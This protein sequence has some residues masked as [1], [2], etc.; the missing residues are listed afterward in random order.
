VWPMANPLLKNDCPRCGTNSVTFTVTAAVPSDGSTENVPPQL[1]RPAFEAFCVCGQCE[2]PTVFRL[3]AKP[4]NT[5][6]PMQFGGYLNRVFDLAGLVLNIP[7]AITSPSH[8]PQDIAIIF[9][10]AATCLAVECFDASGA[11]FRKVLDAATRPLLPS[12]PEPEDKKHPD[13][14]AWKIRKDLKLRLEWLFE[15]GRLPGALRDLADCVR[16]DGNDAA[17]STA[18]ISEAEARDLADFTV[19]L[20]ETIYTLPGQIDDNKRRRAER[21]GEGG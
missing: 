7:S 16:E 6:A 19:V 21:R 20:L 5:Q 10:E 12:Q 17:H 13:F 4:H 3:I 15:R 18:G 8:V 14:I 11:M 1:R 2:L 9:R